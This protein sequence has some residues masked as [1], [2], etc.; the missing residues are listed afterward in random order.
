VEVDRQVIA[1]QTKEKIDNGEE[2]ARLT[3]TPYRNMMLDRWV[4]IIEERFTGH[5]S[6]LPQEVV[7]CEVW[8]GVFQRRHSYKQWSP[9]KEIQSTTHPNERV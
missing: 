9:Q 3:K 5:M 1:N 7:W 6:F 2:Y 8:I 4:M